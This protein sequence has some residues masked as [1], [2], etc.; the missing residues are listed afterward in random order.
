MQLQMFIKGQLIDQVPADPAIETQSMVARLFQK[1]Y[2][3]VLQQGASPQF[4]LSA[5]SSMDRKIKKP[6]RA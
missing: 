6:K 1:N 5:F 4:F 2:K 3:Q